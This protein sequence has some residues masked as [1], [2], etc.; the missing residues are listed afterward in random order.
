MPWRYHPAETVGPDCPSCGCGETLIVSKPKLRD[1]IKDGMVVGTG[2]IG[3]QA[4]CQHCGNVFAYTP[5][6]Q[7]DGDPVQIVVKVGRCPRCNRIAHVY[8][9]LGEVQYRKC[10]CGNT[11]KTQRQTG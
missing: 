5:N 6:G 7:N 3:G 9:T 10:G 4:E 8:K 1:M 11:F 2:L